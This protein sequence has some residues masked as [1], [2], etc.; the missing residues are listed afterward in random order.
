MGSTHQL[1]TLLEELVG[2][3]VGLHC[4]NFMGLNIIMSISQIR[5]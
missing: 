4:L 3:L 5:I 1:P 2:E